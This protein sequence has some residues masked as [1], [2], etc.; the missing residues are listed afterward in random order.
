MSQVQIL[1]LGFFALVT[2]RQTYCTQNAGFVGSTPTK[3]IFN[4]QLTI[5]ND[6]LI[7]RLINWTKIDDWWL[8]IDN[9]KKALVAQS[10][11]A[12]LLRT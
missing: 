6:Q 7:L 3:G 10:E 8:L 2:E 4:Y 1:P 9:W 5:T 11:E 12:L